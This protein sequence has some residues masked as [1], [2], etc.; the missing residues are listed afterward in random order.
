M[1][2]VGAALSVAIMDAADA[3]LLSTEVLDGEGLPAVPLDAALRR[4]DKPG[5]GL[6]RWAQNAEPGRDVCDRD[7]CDEP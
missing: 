1:V 3:A 2:A 7:V 6:C 4:L 5:C